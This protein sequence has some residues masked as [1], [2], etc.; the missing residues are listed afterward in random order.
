MKP[1]IDMNPSR[2]LRFT[3][4]NLFVSFACLFTAI[5]GLFPMYAMTWISR[6]SCVCGSI[7]V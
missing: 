7:L 1:R 5:T 4:V 6:S 2:L 3:R